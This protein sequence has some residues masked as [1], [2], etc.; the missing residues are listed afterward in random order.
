VV[1][2]Q[3]SAESESPEAGPVLR[4]RAGIMRAGP[5]GS[6]HGPAKAGRLLCCTHCRVARHQEPMAP[7][8]AP[9]EPGGVSSI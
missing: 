4:L 8:S 9:A 2:T 1:R 5:L 3:I 6:G 7:D